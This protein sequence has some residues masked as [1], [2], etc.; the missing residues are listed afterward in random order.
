MIFNDYDIN[1]PGSAKSH[2]PPKGERKNHGT[3][4]GAP[5]V[6]DMLLVSSQEGISSLKQKMPHRHCEFRY[7]HNAC[8]RK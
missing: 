6:G 3:Q 1:P 4:V 5:F 7:L 8:N 2:I